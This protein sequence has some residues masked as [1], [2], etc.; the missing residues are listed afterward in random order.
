VAV[1]IIVAVFRLVRGGHHSATPGGDL[2]RLNRRP[3]PTFSF[4]VRHDLRLAYNKLA[5]T[6]GTLVRFLAACRHPS[7]RLGVN[8]CFVTVTLAG[9]H[10]HGCELVVIGENRLPAGTEKPER[11]SKA[12]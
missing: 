1:A 9:T 12:S 10:D 5:M 11:C 8:H 3:G 7:G 2:E 4:E 6:R